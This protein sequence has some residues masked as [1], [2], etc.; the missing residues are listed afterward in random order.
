MGE[1]RYISAFRV[2]VLFVGVCF[3]GFGFSGIGY[4]GGV[5]V[6]D[7]NYVV[8]DDMES[9][10]D[11]NNYMWDTWLDGCGDINGVGGNGTG[12]CIVLATDPCWAVHS[13]TQSMEYWHDNRDGVWDRCARYSEIARNYDPP[14]DWSS[15]G[16][17]ALVIWFRGT[18]SNESAPMYVCLDY[19]VSASVFYG[20]YGED[21]EDI[22][23]EEWIEW[24]ISL[25]DLVEVE[26][27]LAS[28]HEISIGFGDKI[29]N[30]A[31]L[32]D[33]T[34]YF[35]DIRLY[36]ARCLDRYAPAGDFSGD[37][38]VDGRDLGMMGWQWLSI[39][40]DS[41]S[42]TV[43]DAND[44]NDCQS[45]GPSPADGATGVQSV[46]NEVVLE[47]IEGECLGHM[48]RNSIYFGDNWEN[49][50][51]ATI[52]DPEWKGYQ[53]A[54]QN[55]YTVGNLPL[56]ETFYWRINEFNS[57]PGEEPLTKGKVWSFTTGC[58]LSVSDTNLDCVVN[59][60]DYAEFMAGWLDE[61]PFWPTE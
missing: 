17:K 6:A 28:V 57:E 27:D 5:C 51:A 59:L 35:D 40:G 2:I 34:V 14:V 13:G 47:W 8:V 23:Q 42:S 21:P 12:S 18:A 60:K 16:E 32:S 58:E 15:N 48:G 30:E 55:T 44:Y 29:G 7:G 41:N 38:V 10:D 43:Y 19:N 11:S 9:Y 49:V 31:D 54:G 53:R 24:N 33:G 45:K 37:C 52:S 26:N 20:D 3:L 36:P 1:V 46:E 22:K 56:W 61:V 50:N 39:G 25:L 4:D